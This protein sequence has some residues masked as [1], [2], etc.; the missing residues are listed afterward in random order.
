MM[1]TYD[2]N[3]LKMSIT[4][5]ACE[6]V[7][8]YSKNY[9]FL[10]N[11]IAG[12]SIA[13]DFDEK[14]LIVNSDKKTRKY[15]L[16]NEELKLISSKNMNRTESMLF[17]KKDRKNFFTIEKNGVINL[18]DVETMKIVKNTKII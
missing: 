8:G 13:Y 6:K 2:G 16:E 14:H 18:W 12:C 17:M 9:G 11:N 4:D 5:N 1:I 3:L 10:D 7:N 15:L